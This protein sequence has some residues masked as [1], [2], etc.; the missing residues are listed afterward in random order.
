MTEEKTKTVVYVTA[1]QYMWALVNRPYYVKRHIDDMDS[2]VITVETSPFLL[3]K[4]DFDSTLCYDF[5]PDFSII[6]LGAISSFNN[7]S[8]GLV[9]TPAQLEYQANMIFNSYKV[10]L[11]KKLN[12]QSGGLDLALAGG[13]N[14]YGLLN[15]SKLIREDD[16]DS[17]EVTY[18]IGLNFDDVDNPT[19]NIF[20]SIKRGEDITREDNLFE[21]YD[22]P[23]LPLCKAEDAM[24]LLLQAMAND[25]K[26]R[27]I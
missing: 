20:K 21:D 13:T 27:Y 11:E 23:Y 9:E 16:K 7:G 5:N 15:F 4:Y 26:G 19:Y 24:F 3:L 17:Y 8:I 1:E 6:R 22:D 2:T 14:K 10:A 18:A 12:Y 25:N